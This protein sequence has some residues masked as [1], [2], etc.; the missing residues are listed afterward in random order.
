LKMTVILLVE[1]ER[2]YYDLVKPHFGLAGSD[3]P[4]T[5]GVGLAHK[6]KG[7]NCFK[8]HTVNPP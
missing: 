5:A 4:D 3:A 2:I 1:G 7:L 8:T 6:N